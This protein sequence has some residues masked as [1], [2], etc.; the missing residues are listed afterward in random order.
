[1]SG[2][3]SLDSFG[4]ST[5]ISTAPIQGRP[6]S[7][8]AFHITCTNAT[9]KLEQREDLRCENVYGVLIAYAAFGLV[10]HFDAFLVLT[11]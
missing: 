1:M 9:A 11:P 3:Q 4:R 6:V 10:V 8:V 2:R 5:P 7:A